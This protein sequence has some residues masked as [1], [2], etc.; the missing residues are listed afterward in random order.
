M[1][2]QPTYAGFIFFGMLYSPMELILS[3]FMQ[4]FSR[5][6]EYEADHFAASTIEDAE[7]MVKALKKLSRDN[8]TNLTPHSFFVFMN[9]SHPPIL[10]RIR[11]IRQVTV[12]A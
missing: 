1:E 10:D 8:L 9:Y 12:R 5:K 2:N 3:I 11:A 6:N 4:L 7:D